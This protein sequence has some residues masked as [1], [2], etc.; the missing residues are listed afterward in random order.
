MSTKPRL[1]RKRA[2][3]ACRANFD[4]PPLWLSTWHA[5]SHPDLRRLDLDPLGVV[6]GDAS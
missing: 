5:L 4:Q 3:S 1:V 6:D 2:C